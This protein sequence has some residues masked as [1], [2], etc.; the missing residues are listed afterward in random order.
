[1]RVAA[2]SWLHRISG[3]SA[4]AVNSLH[5]Q[6]MDRLAPSL[7]ADATAPDGTVEAVHA[8]SPGFAIG[9]QWHPEYDWERDAVSRAIFELFGEAV[10]ARLAGPARLSAA[11]D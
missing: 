10:R 3:R 4:I 11:A 9:V 7:V 2:G 8:T 6:G 1:V 5:N